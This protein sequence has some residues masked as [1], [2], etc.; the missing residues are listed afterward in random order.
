MVNSF[1]P[2]AL[3]KKIQL[4]LTNHKAN[5]DYVNSISKIE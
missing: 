5:I 3:N 4:I 2:L 1:A